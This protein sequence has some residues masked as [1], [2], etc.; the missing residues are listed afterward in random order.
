MDWLTIIAIIGFVIF[1]I[2][3][4]VYFWDEKFDDFMKN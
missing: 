2:L 3:F 1:C 4:F